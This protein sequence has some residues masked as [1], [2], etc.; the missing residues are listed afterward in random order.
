MAASKSSLDRPLTPKNASA[1]AEPAD[2]DAKKDL[3]VLN[4]VPNHKCVTGFKLYIIVAAVAF[5]GFLMLLDNMIVSTKRKC[6][7]LLFVQFSAAAFDG[8]DIQILQHEGRFIAGFGG[9]GVATGSITII[10]VA[11][12]EARVLRMSHV[13]SWRSSLPSMSTFSSYQ[14]QRYVM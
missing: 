7:T 6:L 10:S 4:P 1:S 8:K 2:A 12:C 3:S 9:A 13:L 14:H 5:V 11:V